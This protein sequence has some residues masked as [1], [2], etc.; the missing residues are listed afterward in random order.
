MEF[1]VILDDED[2]LVP[3][4]ID[5]VHKG[6]HVV[7]SLSWNIYN[8]F[9]TPEEFA[10]KFCADLALPSTTTQKI[11]CQIHDQL[12]AFEILI[13][14]L[15][16]LDSFDVARSLVCSKLPS[17]VVE[18][19][20]KHGIINYKDKFNW[21]PF[22]SAQSPESFAKITCADVGFPADMEPIIS[23]NIREST[24]RWILKCLD[25]SNLLLD[26]SSIV[27]IGVFCC[28]RTITMS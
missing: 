17:H 4:K 28:F 24:I 11:A 8:S 6:A 13:G 22:S 18:M 9:M 21:D 12:S 19:E 3:I 27:N 26:S 16:N 15:R 23:Y 1:P 7:N 25:S 14:M 2:V 10:W 5:V 20:I